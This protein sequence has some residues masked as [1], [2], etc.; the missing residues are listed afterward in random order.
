MA[1][2]IIHREP[3]REYVS[4]GQRIEIWQHA[5]NDWRLFLDGQYQG[6]YN[7][8]DAAMAAAGA[9]LNEQVERLADYQHAA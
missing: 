1:R 8:K 9:W 2:R 6:E 5:W 7:R 4:P 3:T